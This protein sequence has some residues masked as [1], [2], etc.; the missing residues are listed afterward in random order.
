MSEITGDSDL[1]S[2][3]LEDLASAVNYRRWLCSLAV[4]YLGDDP[5][6]IGSGLG[7]YGA[8]WAPSCGAFTVSEADHS[9]LAALRD[10]FTGDER[11]RVRELAVPI[12]VNA[13]HSAV[14]A[15]N[16]LEHIPD[17][18]AALRAFA[19][20]IRPDGAVVLVVPAFPSAMSDFD[21]AIGHQRRYTKRSLATALT[22]AGLRIERLHYLNAP[23]LPIWYG[24]VKLLKRRPK[25][26][27][28]L[29]IYD[30]A[31]VPVT[32]RVEK[33]VRPPFGQSVFAVARR[34]D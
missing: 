20:L 29:T 7:H 15:Y 13:E 2:D 19:G 1:Q 6:E 5:I 10:R 9:R 23:G 28:G 17:E 25:E 33:Y 3:V 32:R 18:V 14:V 24:A 27:L 16:V 4:P 8:E 21:R 34:T 11:I 31:L 26:G 12:E 30:R 22:D